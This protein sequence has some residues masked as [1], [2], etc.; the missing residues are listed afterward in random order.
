MPRS[1]KAPSHVDDWVDKARFGDNFVYP[2]DQVQAA[3]VLADQ[4]KIV[5]FERR[6][7]V[8][9]GGYRPLERIAQ[10]VSPE[11]LAF[12]AWAAASAGPV[13]KSVSIPNVASPASPL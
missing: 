8:R 7:K 4:G 10:R 2:E 13:R 3:A 5:L 6:A 9:I 1:P 11:G 12:M